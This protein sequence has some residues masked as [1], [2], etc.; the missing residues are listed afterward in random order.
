VEKRQY[1]HIDGIID[2]NR[3]ESRILEEEIQKA[4]LSGHRHIEVSAYGQHGIGGRLW[5]SQDEPVHIRVEGHSGQRTGSMGLPGTT[6]EIMGPAS[7]D[8][9]WLNTGAEII[10]HGHASNGVGNAMAQG[11]IFIGGNLGSRA[12]TMT[13]HNPKFEPPELW[14]LG[15]TG[16]YFGEFM[17]GG[18][19]VVC[20]INAQKS[21]NLLG[22]RPLVGMVS[23]K[24]FVRGTL[25]EY[26]KKDAKVI[27]IEN[28]DWRWLTDNLKVFLKKI[29][30]P[31][32]LREL[33]IRSEWKMLRA[34][35]PQER[36]DV[37]K[38]SM[39]VFRKN[40]WNAELGMGGLIGDLSLEDRG[41]IALLPTG[42]FRRSLPVWEN[43][44][45]KA[46]CTYTC[47]TEIPVQ[48]RWQ[49][50]RDGK[51]DEAID[52]SLNYTPFPASVCG[53]LCPNLCMAACSR[54]E[55]MMVPIDTKIL[56]RAGKDLKLPEFPQPTGKKVAIIGGGPAGIAAAWQ[57]KLKG[58]ESV[59]YDIAKKPGGKLTSVIPDSRIPKEILKEEL[60]RINKVLT[61]KHISK[62][63]KEKDINKLKREFDYVIVATGAHKPRTLP[64]P[65]KKKTIT[66][67]D[68]LKKSKL[69]KIKPGKSIVII[70]AGNVGCDVATEAK[71][72]GASDITLID[73]QE[74]A[75][76][77]KE[78]EDAEASGAKF[79][80]PCFTKE[81]T[82]KGVKLTNGETLLADTVVVSIGDTTELDFLPVDIT[83]SNGFVETDSNY[84]TTDVQVFAIGDIASPGLLTEATG[85]G[86]KTALVIH[87]LLSGRNPEFDE[88][89]VIDKQRI[90][91]EYLNPN[92]KIFTDLKECGNECSSCG[93]CRDC[94]IC[95]I[96]CPKSAI[97]RTE[98]GTG[99]SYDVDSER[100]IACGFC[101][102]A[103]PCGIWNLQPCSPVV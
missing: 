21:W 96:I 93:S 57:L 80:W 11:K 35:S 62:P 20:G 67:I 37:K 17:A 66:A 78:R 36:K 100:C 60:S 25:K 28:G 56:G 18:V 3:V 71:R 87:E 86:R 68:F 31:E 55:D 8:V 4:V 48:E 51:T 70:G 23:G 61:F 65:G 72:L 79:K 7:D 30:R 95:E 94:G 58:H 15:S 77:G 73:V 85:S 16:D 42:D 99:Y 45:Y 26:S 49:L 29:K 9:G 14:V 44:K 92:K 84:Q 24:V 76:F 82:D 102:S 5:R 74:P 10:V 2:K 91:L 81:I 53:Y 83:V 52:L 103:C 1:L 63:M 32:L 27:P 64:L 39:K 69:N 38:L 89:E 46:P 40:V 34:L 97:S 12:M 22:H 59:I 33:S 101:A 54:N 6:V 98:T 50:I 88:G 13:K 90:S 47:P 41:Q 19:A 43:R 75:S